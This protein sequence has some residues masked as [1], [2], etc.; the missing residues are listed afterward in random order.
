[1]AVKFAF[2]K[3][4]KTLKDKFICWWRHGPYYHTE[5]ILTEN[6]D[7]TYTIGSAVPGVGVRIAYN[8]T[9]PADEYDIIAGPGDVGSAQ[10]WFTAHEGEGYD[11]LGL[12]G[13][14]FS[15]IKDI[16]KNKWW[17][18]EADLAAVGMDESAWRFDPNTMYALLK[19]LQNVTGE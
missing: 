8:Q 9:L 14:V 15:P 16:S 1:M 11:W 10:A 17:C 12:L 18:S 13:F 5:V 6:A 4:P 19:D 7:G 2:A 3:N